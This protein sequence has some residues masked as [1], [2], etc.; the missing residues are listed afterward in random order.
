MTS[1]RNS[2]ARPNLS[3]L[4]NG[5]AAPDRGGRPP[6]AL[7]PILIT[8]DPA[9]DEVPLPPAPPRAIPAAPPP[10]RP[11]V[12]RP[13]FD[14]VVLVG[15]YFQLAQALLDAQ[16]SIALDWAAL[17]SGLPRRVLARR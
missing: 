12:D 11:A 14:P 5:S 2:G 17:L 8:S 9:A 13:W 4:F 16:R 1:G 15:G 10:G 3:G 7:R 6:G